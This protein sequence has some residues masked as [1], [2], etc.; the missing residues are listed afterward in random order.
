M[1]KQELIEE[2]N[3]EIWLAFH[4]G[5]V[6]DEPGY[7]RFVGE[8]IDTQTIYTHNCKEICDCIGNEYIFDNHEVYGRPDGWRQAAYNALHD[9]IYHCSLHHHDVVVRWEE[10]QNVLDE[11]ER[12]NEELMRAKERDV[13]NIAVLD[14]TTGVVHIHRNVPTYKVK[15]FVDK[16][17]GDTI[18]WMT[19]KGDYF[20]INDVT[21][22]LDNN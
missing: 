22:G 6:N 7:N 21:Y 19:A 17:E 8:W 10:M 13:T 1:T 3:D 4:N 11:Q 5:D 2:F 15:D 16:Y 20:R 18:E 9:L 14:Y 12:L